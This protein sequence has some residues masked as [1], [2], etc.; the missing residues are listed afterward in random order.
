MNP[1]QRRGVLLITLAAL[2]AV[3]VFYGAYVYLSDVRSQ[4]GP[5]VQ[6]ARLTRDVPAYTPITQDVVE[7]ATVPERWVP[8][9]AVTQLEGLVAAADLPAEA[10]LQEG[11]VTSE[12]VIPA[13]QREIAIVVDDESA[14]A[15]KI[16]PED[17]VDVYATFPGNDEV[18]ASSRIVLQDVRVVAVGN[19]QTTPDPDTAFAEQR[20][21][22]VTFALDPRD[23]Q[24]LTY[25]ESFASSVRLALRTPGAL[26][27]ERLPDRE[28]IYAPT[29]GTRGQGQQPAAGEAVE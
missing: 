20:A 18:P 5:M 24:I 26:D 21:V 28:T 13:G 25:V 10:I 16:R 14:V 19:P 23:A 22:P 2:G 29:V 7:V 3:G 17:R 1:R 4:V 11:M 12:P 27:D 8:R 6:V 15:G 9:H